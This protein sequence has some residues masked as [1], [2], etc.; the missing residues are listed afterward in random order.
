MRR[1]S[2][3]EEMR[4]LYVAMTRARE[5][6]ILV[7]TCDQARLD[8]W[9]QRWSEHAGPLP[10]DEVLAGRSVLDWVGPVA[11]ATAAERPH[12]IE[13]TAHSDDE[14]AAMAT[15][16]AQRPQRSALHERCARLEQLSP[17]PA[18]NPDVQRLASRLTQSYSHD[19]YTR[20]PAVL[21]V[22]ALTKE[23]R[24]APGSAGASFR[25]TVEFTPELHPP[26]C[27]RTDAA[28]A[29]TEVG[30]AV[31]A[32]LEHLDF[33]RPCTADDVKR[34]IAELVE[35]RYLAETAARSVDAAAI[36]WMMT[37]ELGALLRRH[38]ASV[39]RELNITF[40]LDLPGDSLDPMDRIMVRGRIDALVVDGGGLV[41]VDYKTD[42]VTTET[43]EP[44]VEFYRAQV[45]SYRDAIANIAELPVRSVYLAFLTPHELR[46]L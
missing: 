15:P 7:G 1:L 3:A 36:A 22:G 37:T 31:H 18:P 13:I 26:R 43:I 11:F 23:G 24:F 44:R 14:V 8:F 12:P 46:V 34:Q 5:H 42:R 45:Q 9:K 35:R 2:L 30:S 10:A 21:S 39:R 17:A 6:L 33:S 19:P 41:V 38:R 20:F 40:P 16:V 25:D 27:A 4:V 28:P 29:P 32:V